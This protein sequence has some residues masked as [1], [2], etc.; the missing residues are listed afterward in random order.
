MK[1]EKNELKLLWPF[2][3]SKFFYSFGFIAAYAV[4]YLK[5]LGL[6]YFQVSLLLSMSYITS[7]LFDI[8]TG[9]VADVFGRRVSVILSHIISAIALISIAFITNFYLLLVV[10][11]LWGVAHTLQTGADEAWIVSNLKC[12]KRSRLIDICYARLPSIGALGVAV[13]PVLAAITVSTIGM[14]YLWLFQ[15]I[16]VFISAFILLFAVETHKVPTDKSFS[17]LMQQTKK[18]FNYG[19]KHPVVFRLVFASVFMS[20]FF[21]GTGLLWQPYLIEL[22]V[23][24][25]YLGYLLTGMAFL[26]VLIPYLSAHLAK[27]FKRRSCYLSLI[28]FVVFLVLLSVIFVDSMFLAMAV[29]SVMFLAMQFISPVERPLFQK[30]LPEKMRATIGSFK[31]MAGT[32]GAAIAMLFIGYVADL[33][34]PKYA[35]ALVGAFLIPAIVLYYGIGKYKH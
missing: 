27:Q 5:G 3:L 13:G 16:L 15:G 33:V 11:I 20:F 32:L 23:P 31:S 35:M 17:S 28:A 12:A 9:A 24:L 26:A 4:I 29:V 7:V 18:S 8:P 34:G 2:Y 14:E 22:N 21:G 6:S 30:F 1:F 10:F 25:S 19:S